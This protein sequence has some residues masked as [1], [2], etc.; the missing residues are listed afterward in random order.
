VFTQKRKTPQDYIDRAT[1]SEA[2][3]DAA[4]SPETRENMLYLAGRWRAVDD[5]AEAQQRRRGCG[6]TIKVRKPDNQDEKV[7]ALLV[8]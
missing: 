6:A 8:S 5:E 7:V 4:T 3:A 2:L 1:A